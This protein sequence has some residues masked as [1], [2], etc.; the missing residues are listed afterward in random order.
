MAP[1]QQI[2]DLLR[3]LLSDDGG[4][5][6]RLAAFDAQMRAINATAPVEHSEFMYWTTRPLCRT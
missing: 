6:G 4:R 3:I 2:A 1:R 5:A